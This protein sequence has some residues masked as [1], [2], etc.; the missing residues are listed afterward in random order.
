MRLATQKDGGRNRLLFS[1]PDNLTR[2]D[3]KTTVSKDR[4][5]LTVHLSYDEGQSWPVERV[6]EPGSSG[7][8]DLSVLPD[9]TILCLY[10]T[11]AGAG[12]FPSR[13]LVLAHFNLEWLT[14]GKDTLKRS[15]LR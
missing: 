1:N 8:S 2:T 4:M 14:N 12:S 15:P 9:G 10:E 5:N 6:V 3:G 7:Y 13:K 11:G